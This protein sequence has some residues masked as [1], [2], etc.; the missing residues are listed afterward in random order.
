MGG[1]M[2]LIQSVHIPGYSRFQCWIPENSDPH[3]AL[4]TRESPQ[5]QEVPVP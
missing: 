4:L 1:A 2:Q 5:R 3:L